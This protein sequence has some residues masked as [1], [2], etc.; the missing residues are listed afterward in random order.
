M[1]FPPFE[2]FR[3]AITRQNFLIQLNLKKEEQVVKGSI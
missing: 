1:H 2:Q 3:S